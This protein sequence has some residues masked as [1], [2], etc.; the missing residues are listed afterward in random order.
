[1]EKAARLLPMESEQLLIHHRKGVQEV[2]KK[3]QEAA[4]LD[5]EREVYEAYLDK[6]M[7]IIIIAE[8]VKLD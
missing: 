5:S 1:M 3:F 2:M 6:L 8:W 4:S 7:V